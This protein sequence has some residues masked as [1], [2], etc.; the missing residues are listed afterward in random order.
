MKTKITAVIICF[1]V[2]LYA[3]FGFFIAPKLITHYATKI[4]LEKDL[5]L[6]LKD[7]WINPFTFEANITGVEVSQKLPI[8]RFDAIYVDLEPS[9]LFD[10]TINI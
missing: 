9:N 2:A 1:L 8:I 7:I 3:A 6:T 10:K 4:A 5:N